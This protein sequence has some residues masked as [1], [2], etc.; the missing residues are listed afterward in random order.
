MQ[1]KALFGLFS[2]VLLVVVTLIGVAA[3]N[4]P[5]AESAVASCASAHVPAEGGYGLTTHKDC[6]AK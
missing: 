4:M 6:A 1:N 3:L 5:S 2:G